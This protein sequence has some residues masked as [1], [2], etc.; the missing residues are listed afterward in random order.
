MTIEPPPSPARPPLF[1]LYEIGD[2]AQRT[3][4]SE[5]YLV[6]LKVHPWRIGARFKRVVCAVLQRP[7]ADL[8]GPPPAEEVP[9]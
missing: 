4:Y 5:V 9:A 3:G 7:E 8:F 6:D 1:S 2:L